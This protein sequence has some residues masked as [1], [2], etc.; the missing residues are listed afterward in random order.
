MNC[1]Q[2][3]IIRFLTWKKR[4]KSVIII[5]FYVGEFLFYSRSTS[6]KLFNII[7]NLNIVFILDIC[8]LTKRF[9]LVG[10]W[11]LILGNNFASNRRFVNA[12]ILVFFVFVLFMSAAVLFVRCT[13]HQGF[14]VNKN[15]KRDRCLGKY[16]QLSWIHLFF[17]VWFVLH[18]CSLLWMV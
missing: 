3:C 13:A 5:I 10:C 14:A 11:T 1:E 8:A 4:E 17:V 6:D 16:V 2:F 7:I 9:S 15:K 12:T 18:V